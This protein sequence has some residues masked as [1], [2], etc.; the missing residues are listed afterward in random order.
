MALN[1]SALKEKLQQERLIKEKPFPLVALL[2]IFEI[3]NHQLYQNYFQ[4]FIL[5]RDWLSPIDI[6]EA[7]EHIK[8]P[9]C[10]RTYEIQEIARHLNTTQ[11][12]IYYGYQNCLAILQQQTN[13]PHMPAKISTIS[14]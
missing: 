10:F 4:D 2:Y 7:P 9:R 13:S 5:L 11:D 8:L 6:P 14:S 1:L 12:N 3:A